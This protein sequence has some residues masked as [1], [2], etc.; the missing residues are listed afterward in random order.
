MSRK[1]DLKNKEYCRQGQITY[2]LKS[3]IWIIIHTRGKQ[4]MD[5][6]IKACSI[7]V[8]RVCHLQT[9]VSKDRDGAV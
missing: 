3:L 9:N 1:R 4:M 2:W 5:F 7:Y 6:K 8:I